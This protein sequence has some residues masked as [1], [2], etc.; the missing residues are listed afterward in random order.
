MTSSKGSTKAI[1]LYQRAVLIYNPNAG[2]LRKN[3]SQLANVLEL[4]RAH[5][6]AVTATATTGPGDATAIAARSVAEGADLIL[7]AGGDGSINEALNGMVGSQVPLAVLPGGTANVLASEVGLGRAQRAAS[8]LREL[9]PVRIAVGV[10][11]NSDRSL[12]RHFICMA[13]AGL[14]AH[15]VAKVNGPV[16]RTFGKLAYWVAGFQSLS[17]SL[18][19]MDAEFDG[20]RVRCSFALVSRVR[21]YGGDLEI[22]RNASLLHNQ[23][24]A[25]LFEGSN[26]FRY[27]KYLTGVALK[28]AAGMSGI[29]A[30]RLDTLRLDPAS[31]APVR[32]QVDGEDAG[33]LPVT[34]EIVP[35]AL[36][37]LLPPRYLA[38]ERKRWTT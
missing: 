22:V 33:Y 38:A 24:G 20:G 29:T 2:K 35:D 21:N 25:Y 13:G 30:T 7:V 37:I 19:E 3:P 27:L 4:L 15:V 34:L 16:K 5:G 26:S 23:L 18:E 6:H 14:D 31:A 32:L 10:V 1:R 9:E 8:L 36:T 11:R 28:T 17:R 12:R